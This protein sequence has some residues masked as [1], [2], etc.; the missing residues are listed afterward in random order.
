MVTSEG[1]KEHIINGLEA[2]AIDCLTKPFFLPELKARVR[3]VLRFKNVHDDLIKMKEQLIKKEM[4]AKIRDTTNIIH[5][6][7]HNNVEI[8]LTKLT[9][10][11][12]HRQ[13]LSEKDFNII[14][15]AAGNIKNTVANLTFLDTL[16]Y[17]VYHSISGIAEK[18]H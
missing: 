13:Y 2:G 14:E 15:S 3:A 17:K 18:I 8:I 7:I 6:T 1:K 9:Y 12:K 5:E 16:T 10:I 11:R 4:T